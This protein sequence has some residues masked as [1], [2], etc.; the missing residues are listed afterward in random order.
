MRK[1]PLAVIAVMLA[2]GAA[3]MFGWI[4]VV[5]HRSA[6]DTGRDLWGI[7]RAA[8]YVA[9]DDLGGVYTPG[10]GMVT[11]PGIA[12]LLAPVAMIGARFHLLESYAPFY[13]P[14]PTVALILQPVELLLAGTVVFAADALADRLGVD[15]RRRIAV[16]ALVG[17][18]AWPVAAVWSHAEDVLAMTF[19]MYALD[20][21]IAGKWRRCGWLLGFGIVMQP[22][23]ALLLPLLLG[24]APS[25]KRALL[26][27]RALVLSVIFVGVA[28]AG[29]P[30]GTY[31]S[32]VRQPTPPSVNHATP[33]SK[34]CS[35]GV[36]GGDRGRHVDPIDLS[37]GAPDAHPVQLDRPCR[38]DRLRR[39]GPDPGSRSGGPSGSLP[40]AAPTECDRPRLVGT[41]DSRVAVLLRG[42]DDA[43]LPCTTSSTWSG[44]R[45]PGP[46]TSV[47]DGFRDHH[48][49]LG[50]R[51]LA[52]GPMVVVATHRGWDGN[53]SVPHASS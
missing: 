33:W 17:L 51:L 47:L 25:G 34:S 21:A 9:W 29:N 7:F 11:L 24:F 6:W 43:V 37:G 32:L 40:G 48:C 14:H 15:R 39:S 20:S 41:G 13:F 22:L 4:P 1:W 19:A 42:G 18:V 52:S 53:D 36:G 38:L 27:T 35:D 50:V 16:C 31:L 10:T 28:F 12:V 44:A 30:S 3:F 2:A 46:G 5:Y 45:E 23:V 26:G 8:H 49:H